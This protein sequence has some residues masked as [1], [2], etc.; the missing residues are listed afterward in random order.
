[1]SFRALGEPVGLDVLLA[2]KAI[3]RSGGEDHIR[4]KVSLDPVCASLEVALITAAF[5]GV[6]SGVGFGKVT[7]DEA[8]STV[9]T[10]AK[11]V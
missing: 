10:S 1:M 9:L 4:C 5:G 3:L 6:L 11:S 8:R 7:V 2:F